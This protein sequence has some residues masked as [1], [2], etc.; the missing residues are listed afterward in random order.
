MKI[1]W[2]TFA[3]VT[4]L[5]LST[6]PTLAQRY[7]GRG[8]GLDP[9][10]R[11]LDPNCYRGRQQVYVCGGPRRGWRGNWRDSQR[12]YYRRG[13]GLDQYGR[14]TDPNCYRGRYGAYVC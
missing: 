13:Y 2:L 9:Y 5:V 11:S 12:G 1:P 7:Y 8:Y 4:V 14:S 6:S 3:A 10:G